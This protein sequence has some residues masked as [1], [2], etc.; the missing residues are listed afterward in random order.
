M[1]KQ[2]TTEQFIIDAKKIHGNKYD[3]SK[4]NYVDAHTKVCITCQEHGDFWQ[5]PYSHL[6]GRG[7]PVCGKECDTV[8]LDFEGEVA[9]CDRCIFMEDAYVYLYDSYD[10]KRT[11]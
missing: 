2:K 1:R 6:N 7:C 9:G 8:Y 4:V 10:K 5:Q 3:Y 11:F